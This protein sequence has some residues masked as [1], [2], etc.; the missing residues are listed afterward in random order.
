MPQH[1]KLV[2]P[3][4]LRGVP[5][6]PYEAE[7]LEF[8]AGD[9]VEFVPEDDDWYWETAPGIVV[10]RKVDSSDRSSQELDFSS[11]EPVGPEQLTLFDLEGIHDYVHEGEDEE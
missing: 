4:T 10:V 9:I 8:V 5:A 3:V 1:Y 6:G 11:L 2:E 7:Y